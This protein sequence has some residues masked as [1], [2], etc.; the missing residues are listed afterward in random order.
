MQRQAII[1]ET[2]KYIRQAE[3]IFDHA[4]KSVNV[5]FN[6]KGQASGMFI[7]DRKQRLIRYNPYIFAKY[8]DYSICNTVPHEVAHYVMYSL[9]GPKAVRP[10]GREWKDLMLKFGATPSRTSSLDLTGIP[11]K[12]YRRHPYTCSCMNHQISSRRHNRIRSGKARYICR[13]CSGEL[14]YTP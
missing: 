3:D 14:V 5:I 9:Y 13:S 1:A 8:F 11:T 10:H 7:A 6:L 4:F 2:Q 12:K